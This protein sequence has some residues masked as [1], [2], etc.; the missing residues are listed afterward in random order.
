MALRINGRG[1]I[2]TSLA[3]AFLKARFGDADYE[4]NMA[5]TRSQL[6]N[7][8]YERRYKE[9]LTNAAMEKAAQDQAAHDA[10]TATGPIRGKT[11]FDSQF[12][13]GADD[14]APV[15]VEDR[16]TLDDLPANID[17]DTDYQPVPVE[18]G[19]QINLP[20][21]GEAPVEGVP[22]IPRFAMPTLPT[23]TGGEMPVAV[24]AETDTFDL[25]TPAVG[26]TVDNGDGTVTHN[27]PN[28]QV[29]LTREQAD[30]LGLAAAY[31]N[32]P[33]GQTQ[34]EAATGAIVYDQGLNL[35]PEQRAA[36]LLGGSAPSKDSIV[37][38]SATQSPTLKEELDMRK[39]VEGLDA[40]KKLSAIVPVYISMLASSSGPLDNAALMDL[41]YGLATAEDP[42]SVVREGDA[43]QVQR[44]GGL[45]GE[46]QGIVSYITGG[47]PI[48]PTVVAR[49]MRTA[50][51]R[52]NAYKQA[53]AHQA[54]QYTDIATRAGWDVRN[55]VP[56]FPE[57][58]D[59]RPPVDP[60]A[61]A[62][63]DSRYGG[64]AG[65]P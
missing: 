22:Q 7:D 8:E 60:A 49:I 9:A 46:L 37:G 6:A 64:S 51:N 40:Y 1:G 24:D 33:A 52:A 5:R 19:D 32:D 34:Q 41:V 48:T 3:D 12:L 53:Y 27:G 2:D 50:K 62:N 25:N 47:Q 42:G 29:R 36:M 17:L 16:P 31:A 57:L 15:P 21:A 63:D 55:A 44:I 30:A 35:T 38:G 65:G 18:V 20:F 39:Q 43:L 14:G 58:E 56:T 26:E 10:Q 11:I 54:Q 28:G 45:S 23:A 13:S 61:A 59:Y 4:M